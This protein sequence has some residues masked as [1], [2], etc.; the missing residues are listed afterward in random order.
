M[1]IL[2]DGEDELRL[3]FELTS[4]VPPTRDLDD[5]VRK[6]IRAVRWWLLT[7]TG[8]GGTWVDPHELARPFG[9]RHIVIGETITAMIRDGLREIGDGPD[10]D[11]VRAAHAILARNFASPAASRSAS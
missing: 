10:L 3:I 6:A 4:L 1:R 8:P 11:R 9:E 5:D 2:L 7:G